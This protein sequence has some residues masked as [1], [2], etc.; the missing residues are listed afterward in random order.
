M[1]LPKPEEIRNTSSDTVQKSYKPDEE[2]SK[3]VSYLGISCFCTLVAADGLSSRNLKLVA[4]GVLSLLKALAAGVPSFHKP[5]AVGVS[6][7]CK[8]FAA[9]LPSSRKPVAAGVSSSCKPR[10]AGISRSRKPNKA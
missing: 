6:S 8:L 2:E 5:G 10:A 7:P 1:S 4:V 9:G 3:R